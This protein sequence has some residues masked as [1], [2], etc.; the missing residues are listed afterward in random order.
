[1]M[2][3]SST[4]MHGNSKTNPKGIEIEELPFNLIRRRKNDNRGRNLVFSLFRSSAVGRL[5][6][7][8]IRFVRPCM[9]PMAWK[10]L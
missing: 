7:E 2:R 5:G 1:M 6:A 9:N 8:G 10:D 3:M 4:T